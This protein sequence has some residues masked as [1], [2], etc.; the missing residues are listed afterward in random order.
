MWTAPEATR[1]IFRQA[2]LV[3]SE[4][5]RQLHRLE[6][7]FDITM[8]VQHGIK[9]FHGRTVCEAGGQMV[10]PFLN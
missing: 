6:F 2:Q 4:A 9:R 5:L 7:F 8:Q 3:S 10:P 1:A